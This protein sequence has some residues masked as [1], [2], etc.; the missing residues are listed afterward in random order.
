MAGEATSEQDMRAAY[1]QMMESPVIKAAQ[2]PWWDA[3]SVTV[4]PANDTKRAR[5]AARF[6]AA[7]IDFAATRRPA[8][9]RAR[10]GFN[11]AIFAGIAG[12]LNQA[13]ARRDS[14]VPC[15]DSL[16]EG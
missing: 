12:R 10:R 15:T 6:V 13:I 1:R 9:C 3:V 16:T 4:T 8:P 11:E 2:S 14:S 7:E 5:K